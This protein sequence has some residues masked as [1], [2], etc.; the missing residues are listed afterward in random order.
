MTAVLI[1]IVA[2]LPPDCKAL[3]SINEAKFLARRRPIFAAM[4][5]VT[6]PKN[7]TRR[8]LKSD[9]GPQI[10]GATPWTIMKIVIDKFAFSMLM[11]ND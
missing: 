11:D 10:D 2:E 8:P 7:A 4:V 5:R 9:T 1:A 3:N 6:A